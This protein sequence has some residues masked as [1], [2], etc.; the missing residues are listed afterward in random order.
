[1]KALKKYNWLLEWISAALLLAM[2]IVVVIESQIVLYITGA[3]FVFMGV[4]RIVPLIKTTE[5]KLMKYL[6]TAEVVI[7]VLCG[8]YLFYMGSQKQEVGRV[9]GYIVGGVFY[10]RGFTHFIATSLRG[11]PNTKINFF[12]NMVLLTLGV[13]IISYGKIDSKLMAWIIFAALIICVIFLSIKG[14]KDYTNYRGTL[15][16][17]H[18]TKKIKKAKKEETVETNPTAEEIKIDINNI[19]NTVDQDTINA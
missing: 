8:A 11:E 9:Y 2:G 1:M 7:E 10:L 13:F 17:E 4:L 15:V 14:V 16:S 5:D 6:Q 18:H 12:A 3:I 19:D